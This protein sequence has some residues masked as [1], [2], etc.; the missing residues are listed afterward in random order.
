MNLLNWKF[1][2]YFW[3]NEENEILK[4]EQYFTP[5]KS[6]DIFTKYFKTIKSRNG[7]LLI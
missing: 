5:K 6:E 7:S 2:N 1:R 3:I 4:S